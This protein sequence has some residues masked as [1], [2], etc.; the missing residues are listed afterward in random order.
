MSPQYGEVRPTNGWDLLAIFGHHSTFQP[1]LRLGF[2]IAATSLTGSQP[3]FARCLAVSWS[4]TLY[5]HFRGLLPHNKILPRAKFTLLP[6]FAFSYIGSV[7]ARLSSSGHQRKFA[8]S[9]RE[10]SYGTFKRMPSILGWAAIT[11]GIGPH[12]SCCILY[13]VQWVV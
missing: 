6:S 4:G 9:Y 11:L 10:W 8:A 2:V 7:T 5:V 13:L 3:N 1:V 12:S